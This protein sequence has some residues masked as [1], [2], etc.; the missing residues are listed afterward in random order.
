MVNDT[1]KKKKHN[2]MKG[3]VIPLRNDPLL[4]AQQETL[5]NIWKYRNKPIKKRK[6]YYE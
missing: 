2:W 5:S 3:F 4:S 6:Y 1:T